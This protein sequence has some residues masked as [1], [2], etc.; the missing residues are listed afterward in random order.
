MLAEK[1]EAMP[2]IAYILPHLRIRKTTEVLS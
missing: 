2:T 1:A